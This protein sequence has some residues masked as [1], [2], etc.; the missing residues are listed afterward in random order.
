VSALRVGINL[1]WLRPGEGGG[2]EAYAMRVIRALVEDP[3]P[4][5]EMTLL[6]NRRLARAR[7]DVGARVPLAVAPVDGAVRSTR[8]VAESTWLRR[9]AVRRRLDVVHHMADVV[10]WVRGDHP[11]VLTIHDLRA[12]HRPDVL[13]PLH[14]TYLRARL[15]PSVRA[16]AVVTTPSATV[17]SAVLEEL[18]AD[19]DRVVVVSAPLFPPAQGAEAIAPE[20]AE[21]Y[22]LYP[23]TTDPH[24]GHD[25]LLD[26][27]ATV[28]RS[29]PGMR[30]VLTGGRGRA[31]DAVLSAIGRLGLQDSVRRLGLVPRRRLDALIARAV[32]LVYPSRYEGF[33]LP[34]A[35]AMAMGCPV[36]ASDL[37]VVREVVGDAGSLVSPGDVTGWA[38]AML[39]LLDDDDLRGRLAAAG[40]ERARRFSP[41]ET[42]RRMSAAYRLAAGRD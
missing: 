27:F 2:A 31:E 1:L 32:A 30:L 13:G 17:R 33:G 16:S 25:T 21:P 41:A 11:S 28:V 26:A 6:V 15:R 40:T 18:G 12:L 37:P 36:I 4:E 29:R 5:V 19:P 7:P 9:E 39:R 38:D 20:F 14:A 10:P 35:E 42:S 24:K 34:L 8:I 23:A 22:F 3:A